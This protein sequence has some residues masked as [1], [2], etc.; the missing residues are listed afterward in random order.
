MVQALEEVRVHRK[1]AD[2]NPGF[3]RQLQMWCDLGFQLDSPT[4][5]HALLRT[6]QAQAHF[7]KGGGAP[8]TAA[9]KA[10]S[11]GKAYR[12]GKCGETLFSAA[13]VLPSTVVATE[14]T[15]GVDYKAYD[16]KAYASEGKSKKKA[17]GAYDKKKDEDKS[18]ARSAS[19]EG[20][21]T[22]P[23]AWMTEPLP[24]QDPSPAGKINCPKCNQKLGTYR[25][26]APLS[27]GSRWPDKGWDAGKAPVS[28]PSFQISRK[29]VR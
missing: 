2:P 29:K 8:R 14:P 19:E 22:E 23:L 12:C 16:Y 25:W 5:L 11:S 20:L 26:A 24:N 15:S 6:L 21:L 18:A 3:E 7:D 9:L 10:A 1:C 4:P 27:G 28:V 13:N 17:G